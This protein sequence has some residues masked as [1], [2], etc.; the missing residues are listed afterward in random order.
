MGAFVLKE[1]IISR[2]PSIQKNCVTD[3][4]EV[5]TQET[6]LKIKWHKNQWWNFWIAQQLQNEARMDKNWR[7]LKRIAIWVFEILLG[8]KVAKVN[9]HYDYKFVSYVSCH[10]YHNFDYKR[11]DQQFRCDV[12]QR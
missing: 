1:T 10:K 3:F 9:L 8:L 11:A 4:R 12:F 2:F 5:L 6:G 7:R